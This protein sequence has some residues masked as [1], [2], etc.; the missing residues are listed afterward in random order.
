MEKVTKREMYEAIKA[1]V[2][3]GEPCKYSVEMVAEF[4]DKE[5]AALDKRA[6]KAKER[7]AA[8]KVEADELMDKVAGVL[9]DEYQTIAD[10]AGVL[11]AED[12]DITVAKITY[13]L[14]KLVESGAVEKTQISIPGKEK[15]ERAR[16]VQAYKL[17]AVVE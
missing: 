1:S 17:T 2:V 14:T 4:C 8:K 5:I 10:I 11:T 15:G 3:T 6:E 13:R 9:T 16:R 12:E 7:S